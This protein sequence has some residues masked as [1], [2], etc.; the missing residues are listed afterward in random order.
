MADQVPLVS[1]VLGEAEERL[2][3]EVLRSGQLAQGPKVERLEGLFCEVTGTAHAVALNSGTAALA[4]SLD[5]LGVG[6]GDEVIT[7]PLTFGATL[8]AIIKAGAKAKF[9]DI[10]D[11]LTIDPLAVESLI[12]DRTVAVMPVHLYGLPADMTRIMRLAD[13]KGIPI[14]EDAAQAVGATV[15]GRP[16]GSYGL[17]CFSL[18]ATKNVT[19]GEGG[20]VTTDDAGLAGLLRLL[21]NQGMRGRY[22]YARIG[23]NLR[24]TDVQAALGIPQMEQL[25]TI[26]ESR[27]RN[28]QYLIA[29]LQGIPGLELPSVPEGRF[30]VFH[31]FT[32]RVHGEALLDRDELASELAVAGV[33]SSVHYP[34]V[35][36]DYDC[37]ADHPQVEV[38]DVPRAREAAR[39]VLSLPVHQHLSGVDLD[40]VIGAVG[41]LLRA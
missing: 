28:A 2:V 39:Q 1:V 34:R 40:T 29:G 25:S 38:G 11:D 17:G 9:A 15:E 37:Y 8:N 20:I 10:T 30:H 24:L 35:V 26:A 33:Q 4:A 13:G 19:T 5:V 36:F 22:D 3:L 23:D 41:H 32:V 18:Y 14:V 6:A 31:Q 27:R 12:T 16:V 21:R 7:S